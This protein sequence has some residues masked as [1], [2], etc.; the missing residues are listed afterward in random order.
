[1]PTLRVSE[2]A[3]R[4]VKVVLTGDGGDE[5]FAGYDKYAEYF[6]RPDAFTQD[7]A[8]FRRSYFD[9]I[10]LF[11]PEA[12]MAL[13]RP[14]VARRLRDIDSFE[15]GRA[16]V[17]RAGRAVRPHQPGAVPGHAVA[18]V[19]EQPGEAGPHGHG[20]VHRGAHALPGLADDG[21][22]LPLG[23]RPSCPPGATRSIGTSGR[24]RR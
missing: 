4:H 2:L 1:M 9:A 23:G 21:V 11:A 6:A 5:L 10:S 19:R 24:S 18:A 20:G 13:Y 22:R 12:K 17:V 15:A 7:E 8:A 14:E 16:A 3:A